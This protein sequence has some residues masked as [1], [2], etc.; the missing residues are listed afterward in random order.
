MNITRFRSSAGI[1]LRRDSSEGAGVEHCRNDASRSKQNHTRKTMRERTPPTAPAPAFRCVFVSILCPRR[2]PAR[3]RF[4]VLDLKIRCPEHSPQRD[5][6]GVSSYADRRSHP[7]NQTVLFDTDAPLNG[8]RRAFLD[9]DGVPG[10]SPAAQN[11]GDCLRF[12]HPEHSLPRALAG[13]YLQIHDTPPCSNQ[14]EEIY[15][16][17]VFYARGDRNGSFAYF[18]MAEILSLSARRL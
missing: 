8:V 7:E 18:A 9:E 2:R 17:I 4:R 16:M 11:A 13:A 6:D 12:L 5:V 15:P 1:S 10:A 14:L 3:N